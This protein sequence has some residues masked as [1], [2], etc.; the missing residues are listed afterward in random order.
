MTD[1]RFRDVHHRVDEITNFLNN[2]DKNALDLHIWERDTSG[3]KS[4]YIRTRVYFVNLFSL[5]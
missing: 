4:A 2:K 1:F 5:E 3:L